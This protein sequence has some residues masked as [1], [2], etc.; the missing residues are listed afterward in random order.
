MAAPV[1]AFGR[2]G[3]ERG[4]DESEKV[5]TLADFKVPF[6]ASIFRNV[7]KHSV[8]TL[9]ALSEEAMGLEDRY[10]IRIIKPA[11]GEPQNARLIMYLIWKNSELLTRHSLP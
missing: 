5:P 11:K 7:A 1:D 10:D 4:L 6:R 2:G 8:D 9:A 3:R